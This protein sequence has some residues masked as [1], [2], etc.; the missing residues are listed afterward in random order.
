[1]VA[2]K[3]GRKGRKK[4]A[5][6]PA[7]RA[8]VEDLLQLARYLN[9]EDTPAQLRST[10]F[11][12]LKNFALSLMN[13]RSQ[14]IAAVDA[15]RDVPY[16]QIPPEVREHFNALADDAP[17]YYVIP[18]LR[19][20]DASKHFMTIGG[21][22]AILLGSD[23]PQ[24]IWT[25]LLADYLGNPQRDRLRRC[26]TCNRWFVDRTKNHS[27]RC[28]SKK[29]TIAYSNALRKRKKQTKAGEGA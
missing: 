13:A 18:P 15:A 10:H 2:A 6:S 29:C 26:R 14:A 24:G 23:V 1:M 7:I 3:R 25:A 17:L 27:A 16:P 4:I 21:S 28:C 20:K 9:Q 5:L 22:K 11:A 19:P 12:D 8:Q